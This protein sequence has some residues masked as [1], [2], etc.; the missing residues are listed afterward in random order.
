MCKSNP[1]RILAI[2]RQYLRLM[3]SQPKTSLRSPA[4]LRT[5]VGRNY[6]ERGEDIFTGASQGAEVG[7]LFPSPSPRVG[8][9]GYLPDLLSPV[10]R[11]SRRRHR[12]AGS[13]FMKSSMMAIG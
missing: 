13:G 8:R 2:A 9:S 7:P 1:R 11:P 6:C 5:K 10:I 3:L 12:A 4:A